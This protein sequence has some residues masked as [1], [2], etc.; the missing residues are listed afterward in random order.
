MASRKFFKGYDM[1]SIWILAL[2]SSLLLSGCATKEYVR[3][4]VRSQVQPVGEQVTR[5]DQRV[6]QSDAVARANEARLDELVAKLEA[7]GVRVARTEADIAQLSRTAREAL[8]RAEEARHL[9]Q[10]KLIYEV[11]L[12]NDRLKFAT[13]SAVLSQAAKAELDAF[14]KTLVDDDFNVYIEIQGHTDSTGSA[15]GNLRLGEA[16]AEAVRRHLH[17]EAGIPL[18]RLATISYGQSAP[19]ASNATRAGREQNRRVVLVVIH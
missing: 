8:E 7:Q 1:K 3:E 11:M 17:L 9:A 4:Y 12:S 10:G 18:H 13:G 19:V 6:N 5:L 15:A 14:A 16:R 2:L